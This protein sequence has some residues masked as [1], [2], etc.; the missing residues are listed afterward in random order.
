[1]INPRII[2]ALGCALITFSSLAQY[3]K[4]YHP[5]EIRHKLE[6]LNVLGSVLYVAAHPDDE[7][8]RMIA[9]YANEE[10]M[11]T[12]YLAATRGDGGQNLIGPE[13]REGLGVIR[14]QELLGARRIDGGQ[15]FFSRANDFGYSKNPE[16]TFTIWDRDQVLSDFVWVFRKFRPD[17]IITRF[18][19]TGRNHGHHTA[20]AI[21][22]REA[23]ELAGD[24]NAFPDQLSYVDTWA[25]N[26]IYWNTGW[27]WF[28]N[29]GQDTTGLKTI[30]VG[31]FN[32]LLGESYG[33]ISARSRSMHKSQG[34]GSSGSRGDQI[35]YLEQWGGPETEK[36]F[37]GI[38]TSWGRVKGSEEVSFYI[39]KAIN[40]YD[41]TQ[42]WNIVEPL[43]LARKALSNLEDQFWGEVK[44][45]EIDELIVATTG[46]YLSLKS[47]SYTYSVGDS[48]S[49]ALE[50]V[51]RSDVDIRVNEVKLNLWQEAI[52]FGAKLINNRPFTSEMNFEIPKGTS[53]STPYWL[54]NEAKL[55]MYTVYDQ[56][57]IGTPENDPPISAVVKLDV[58]GEI[59]DLT[60]PVLYKRTDPV[61]GEVT[62]PLTIGPPVMANING[63]VLVFGDDNS[64]PVD[65]RVIAGKNGIDGELT[66]QV[67]KGWKISPESH[68]FD[69]TRKGEEQIF[70]FNVS[71]PKKSS[72]G[73]IK[74]ILKIGGKE[75]SR[76][77]VVIDYDHVPTQ[78]FYP[79]SEVKIVKVDLEKRGN[80]IGYIDGA[81][82]EIPANLEQVGYSVERLK[83]DDVLASNLAKYDAIILG[84]RAFNT[85]SWLSY[86]NEELFEYVKGGGNLIVQ[87][88]TSHRLVTQKVAPYDLKLSRERVTVEGAPVD[89]IDESH[90]LIK[91]P[92]KITQAD[93]EG[94]VQERGLYFPNEWSEDFTPILSSNDPG[95][96][97]KNGGLLVAKYG[98]GH[99]VYSGYSWFRELPAGV[100][101]AY[102]IFV[103]MI[104]L[105]K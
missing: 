61:D 50:A 55:G 74:T 37:D 47:N 45:K 18:N 10:L 25:P 36:P 100:P 3:P 71:P 78:T 38:D 49:I 92:N 46:L 34:F 68:S 14:T 81:G 1:M 64:K 8:T 11:R 53:L 66:L 86:K 40:E 26:K 12:G 56:E 15:Q 31:N 84:V 13:I 60:I 57:L 101:G 42:P 79:E 17:I 102:R 59:V 97:P 28:R 90:P 104:S 105:G 41:E 27:W 33:E 67:P 22:A 5:G 69:L 58:G 24:E 87:Y 91:G 35:E 6:K 62:E 63:G 29:S 83:K 80:V 52:Q 76:G 21:L 7:N 54:K 89:I 2:V 103:N 98:E 30:N 65:V 39:N 93:F 19:S 51:N 9:Y 88:N 73:K 70:T 85:V 77:R 32:P 99:Y 95:E 20:S 16:E 72:E 82:D 48:I 96:S 4:T 44:R 94:W 75:Y 43:V 23:F